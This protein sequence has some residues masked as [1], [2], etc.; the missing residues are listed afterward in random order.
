M[1][2]MNM[3]ESSASSIPTSR[4]EL[5]GRELGLR[6]RTN[7]ADVWIQTWSG[8][9]CLSDDAVRTTAAPCSPA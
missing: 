3:F 4:P 8:A 6:F 2:L 5:V 9:G 1:A 7:V